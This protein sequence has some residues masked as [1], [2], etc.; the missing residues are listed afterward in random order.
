MSENDIQ[1]ST[2]AANIAPSPTLAVD[3][4]AKA[5]KAAGED[6]CGFGA[7]EPDFDTPEFIKAACAKALA[8]VRLNMLPRL[9]FQR[10]V[11]SCREV[12]QR[13]RY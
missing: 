5:M 8:E 3:S 9:D 7:G 12:F 13:E 6:V 4:K 1:L 2:W 10:S 11:R